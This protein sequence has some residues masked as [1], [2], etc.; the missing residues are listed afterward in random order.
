VRGGAVLAALVALVVAAPIAR[1]NPVSDENARTGD[2][3]WQSTTAPESS[4]E[5]YASESSVAPGE[6]LHLH[7]AA[8]AARYRI[9]VHRLGYYGGAGGRRVACLPGPACT[10]DKAPASQPA[11]A[12]PDPNTGMLDAGWSVTDTLSI[13]SDW[14]SGQYVAEL[15][16]TTGPDAGKSA[17]V[18]FVVRAAA[19][20]PASQVV[21]MIPVNTYVAY[22][23]WGGKS[24]YP[25]NSTNG[26]QANHVSFNRPLQDE[27]PG[28]WYTD[29]PLVRYLESQGYDLSYVADTDVD[30]DPSLLLTHRLVMTAGHGEYWTKA[31]RDGFDAARDA[32][33]NLAFM[34]A[35]NGYWQ[36]RYEDGRRTIVAYKESAQT[37]DPTTDRSQL[38]TRFALLNPPRDECQLEGVHFSDDDHGDRANR[39]YSVTASGVSDPW[40]ANAGFLSGDS[41]PWLVGYEWDHVRSGCG[42]PTVLFHWE[43]PGGGQGADST[44]YTA[45]SGSRVFASG[46]MQFAWGLGGHGWGFAPLAPQITPDSRLLVFM[47][48]ALDDLTRPA[49]PTSLQSAV[50]GP[51]QVTVSLTRHPDAQAGTV[52]VYRHAGPG[53]FAPGDPGVTLACE[54]TAAQCVSHGVPGHRQYRFAAVTVDRWGAS[55]PA[56]ADPVSLPNSPPAVSVGGDASPA[57]L[58]PATFTV[59]DQDPDGDPVALTWAVDGV[60]QPGANGTSLT[61]TWDTPGHHTVDVTGSDGNGASSTASLGVDVANRPPTARIQGPTSF[62]TLRSA[63]FDAGTSSD[64]EGASL[65]YRWQ[66]DGRAIGNGRGVDVRFSAPG[67][68]RLE[69]V[70]GD[71]AGGTSKAAVELH[72]TNRLPLLVAVVPTSIRAGRVTPFAAFGLDPDGRVRGIAWGFPDARH[73]VAGTLVRR[74][75]ARGIRGFVRARPEPGG[76]PELSVPLGWLRGTS[77]REV[78]AAGALTP[79]S[80]PTHIT[81]ERRTCRGRNC[82]YLRVRSVTVRTAPDGRFSLR[83]RATRDGG[84]RFSVSATPP[85]GDPRFVLV[86]PTR[87]GSLNES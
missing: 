22:S 32:G 68:H 30:A 81:I 14:V 86:V 45:P 19:G 80:G 28:P 74:R 37:D 71:G 17:V 31:M 57:S 66:L 59:S 27:F 1:A 4:I 7:V 8:P 52:R 5:G 36:I 73:P 3:L 16:L 70:V 29:Y 72:A 6:V 39:A 82:R 53:S 69:I 77:A 75:M 65:E 25:H 78:L 83:Y 35:N 64:P 2:T 84:Y 58:D 34:G 62:P 33:V 38:T 44:R 18:S 60:V 85:P 13:P 40:M 67:A 51:N 12:A 50:S 26:V 11:P 9:E 87:I 47:H 55:Q 10:N 42:D 48:N 41:L 21:V 54:T 63:H 56:L 76:A 24:L 49:P 20:S 79:G 46:S 15:I 43:A 23:S 61:R